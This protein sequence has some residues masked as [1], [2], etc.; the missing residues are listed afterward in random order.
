MEE[1]AREQEQVRRKSEH[2]TPM[3]AEHKEYRNEAKRERCDLRRKAKYILDHS[4][5]LRSLSEL[6]ITLTE[7][8]AIAA[9][10]IIG[11]RSTPKIG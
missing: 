9:A 7:L 4:L 2:M 8:A 1:R 11:E 3:F 5:T 6:A 10:A